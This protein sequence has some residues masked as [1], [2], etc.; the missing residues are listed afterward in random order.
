[1]SLNIPDPQPLSAYDATLEC[2]HKAIAEELRLRER[3]IGALFYQMILKAKIDIRPYY[4]TVDT[5]RNEIWA[6]IRPNEVLLDMVMKASTNFQLRMA[7]RPECDWQLLLKTLAT[8]MADRSTVASVIVDDDFSKK[9]TTSDDLLAMMSVDRWLPFVFFA[10][11][12]VSILVKYEVPT[13]DTSP[14]NP[15]VS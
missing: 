8:T 13:D 2:L 9:T 15:N 4:M 12:N 1:M 7:M 10:M 14:Q 6:K 5:L 3:A 11:L